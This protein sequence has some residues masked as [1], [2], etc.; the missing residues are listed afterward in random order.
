MNH[1][2]VGGTYNFR[3]IYEPEK[4][5]TPLR[6]CQ[7]ATAQ[8]HLIN[9]LQ[10]PPPPESINDS[11]NLTKPENKCADRLPLHTG[12][13]SPAWSISGPPTPKTCSET[14]CACISGSESKDV[15]RDNGVRKML[16]VEQYRPVSVTRVRAIDP[17]SMGTLNPR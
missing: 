14:T 3:H 7:T 10:F 16:A 17:I 4:S 13:H 11:K 5:E 1:C 8:R 2:K 9:Y 6:C 12:G 15:F